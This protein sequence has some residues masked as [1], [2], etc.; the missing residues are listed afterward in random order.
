MR[1]LIFQPFSGI[2]DHSLLEFQL[3]RVLGKKEFEISVLNCGG[4]FKGMCAVRQNF[5]MNL[6]NTQEE[7]MQICKKCKV[8]SDLGLHSTPKLTRFILNE[9][10]DSL[11]LTAKDSPKM[12][13]SSNELSQEQMGSSEVRATLYEL[14]LKFK[15][16]DL[17]LNEEEVQ[18]LTDAITNYRTT[19]EL[20]ASFLDKNSFDAV[21]I[22]NPQYSINSAMA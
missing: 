17:I 11:S 19:R 7:L 12:F 2:W 18:Y 8:A 5:G 16:R 20:T 15:K 14:I 6:N 9:M 21:V 4:V 22:Y 13:E 1:I 10:T 3:A